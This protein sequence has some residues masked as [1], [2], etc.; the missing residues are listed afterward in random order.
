MIKRKVFIAT[1][2][3]GGHVFPAYSLANYLNNKN[4][5]IQ[6]L[7]DKRGLR[8]LKDYKHLNLTIINSSPLIKTNP[9][10]IIIS[11]FIIFISII[12]SFLI[13]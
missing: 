11:I 12:K 5:N 6:M 10:K 3:S 4:F 1:G 9:L 13:I 8:Y 2:G 7:T